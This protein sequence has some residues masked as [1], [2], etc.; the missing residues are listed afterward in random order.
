METDITTSRQ[1]PLP[2]VSVI[3]PVRNEATHIARTLR[4]I[5]AQDYP[6]SRTEVIVVDGMSSDG[7]RDIVRSFQ[8]KQPRIRLVDNPGK[9]APTGL[10]AALRLVSGSI[11]IRIDGHCEPAPDYISRCTHH[12]RKGNIDGVGGPID[13]IGDSFVAKVIAAAMSSPFGVGGSAF[14]TVKNRAMEVETIAFPAYTRRAI[15]KTGLYD[16]QLVRNQ[17]DEYNYRLIKLGGT[18]LLSPDIRSRYFSRASLRSLWR[19]Y[20]QY[21]FWKVRV[22]QKHPR[23]MRLRQFVPPT[24]VMTLIVLAVAS[25]WPGPGR[26]AILA[27]IAAY[28]A[29]LLLGSFCTSRHTGW[30]YLPIFPFVFATIHLSYGLGFIAG[31]LRFWNTWGDRQGK[32]PLFEPVPKAD[33][34]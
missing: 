18:L 21:G 10:N 13:T 1:E 23:Q 11:I 31:L 9:I 3:I 28:L 5:L 34:E 15:Q 12:L 6:S 14:R 17:D 22:M 8:A 32:V 30:S 25:A 24:L 29:A 19:Q 26:I 2:L 33:R 4:A 27:V 7:T 20:F 16:E